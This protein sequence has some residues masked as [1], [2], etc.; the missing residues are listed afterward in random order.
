MTAETCLVTGGAR[1]G[2]SAFAL[3]MAA[4]A[5]RPFFIATGWAGDAEMLARIEK[6]RAERGPHWTTIEA[7][8]HAAEAVGEAV[9]R[10]ADFI[11]FDCLTLWVSNILFS[12][13]ENFALRLNALTSLIPGL[14]V[15][16]V[17]VTN[18]TG[19]G[20]VPGD[21]VSREFR[22]MAGAANKAVAE[23]VSSVYVTFCGI[24]L[25]LK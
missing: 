22:D 18:E 16:A 5:A 10:G 20:I 7:K 4:S 25:K 14:T 15:P 24:P 1:S 3:Q 6:H 13:K 2:K 23:A 21:A 17:F 9:D 19:M 8:T 11:V 12:E